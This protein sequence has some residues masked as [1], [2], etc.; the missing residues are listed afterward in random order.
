MDTALRPEL[1]ALDVDGTLLQT[2]QPVSPRVRAAVRAAVAAGAHVVI[3]TGRTLLA[4]RLVVEELGIEEGQALCSNGAVHV[5]VSNWQ[6]LALHTFDPEPAVGVL[7]SLF[8]DM[9]LSVEKP[10][11]GTWTTGYYPGSFRLGEFRFVEDRELSLEPTTRLNGWWPGGTLADMVKH[12]DELTLPGA[13]WVHGE[14]E[15]FLVASKQGVSKGWALERLRRQLAIPREATLAI[16]D[17][18]NDREMLTWA[19]HS[20]AMGNSVLPILELADEITLDVEEDGA[21]VILERW[22]EN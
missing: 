13:G 10:G 1:I 2:G 20:V 4:T 19:G 8:P 21:A 11:V 16:G 18:Y 5:D 22:F 12:L 14:Y 7:R 3:T 17:G 15:P 9:V 6:P